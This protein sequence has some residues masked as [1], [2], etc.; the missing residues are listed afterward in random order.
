VLGHGEVDSTKK[1]IAVDTENL[2]LC[3]LSF[4]GI[5]PLKGVQR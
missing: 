2:K 4:A 3:A 1:Y 5:K